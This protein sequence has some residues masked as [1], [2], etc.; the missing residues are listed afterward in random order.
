MKAAL[1]D[2]LS[3]VNIMLIA[4]ND[5]NAQ[6]NY[7]NTAL[8]IASKRGYND[9]VAQLLNKEANP[10]IRTSSGESALIYAAAKN[11]ADVCTTLLTYNAFAEFESASHAVALIVAAELNHQEALTAMLS[12]KFDVDVDFQN[13]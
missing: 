5:I 10:D 7:G 1:Q 4:G 11:H 2:H 6:N 3:S 12:A 13:S 9:I 8:I